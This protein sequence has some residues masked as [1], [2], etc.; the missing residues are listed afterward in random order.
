M[1]DQRDAAT[2]TD[3]L[4]ETLPVRVQLPLSEADFLSGAAAT[5]FAEYSRRSHRRTQARL[6]AAVQT[7]EKWYASYIRDVSSVGLGL[8]SPIQLFPKDRVDV[9]IPEEQ[10]LELIIRRCRKLD[11]EC[12]QC[13]GL[14]TRGA[15][16]PGQLQR[17]ILRAESGDAS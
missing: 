1:L 8:V 2:M 9:W 15:I 6:R 16:S 3:E 7:S 11:R 12:F 13:G 10:P 5:G 17:L 4:W 14:F